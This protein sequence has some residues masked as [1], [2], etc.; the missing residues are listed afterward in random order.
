M[1]EEHEHV[2]SGVGPVRSLPPRPDGQQWYRTLDDAIH[3]WASEQHLQ[4][5][6]V[7]PEI[8][9]YVGSHVGGWS[10]G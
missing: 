7:V 5:D 8:H 9:V 6:Q 1:S 3:A 4:G 10:V 2:E